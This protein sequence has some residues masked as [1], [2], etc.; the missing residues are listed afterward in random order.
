[1]S[2][3]RVPNDT[4]RAG[5]DEART[6]EYRSDEIGAVLATLRGGAQP[7]AP[8]VRPIEPPTRALRRAVEPGPSTVETRVDV[9]AATSPPSP[10]PGATIRRRLHR[11]LPMLLTGGLSAALGAAIAWVVVVGAAPAA[12]AS[13]PQQRTAHAPTHI[14]EVVSDDA[15][16]GDGGMTD[17]VA[18]PGQAS[19][20][21]ASGSLEAARDAYAQLARRHPR[22]PV[23]P[24]LARVLAH[25][26]TRSRAG[27]G[28]RCQL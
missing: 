21:L 5:D 24:L 12:P 3:P 16:L 2:D 6:R 11:H 15:D 28:R 8:G 14:E 13:G 19:G 27:E 25:C 23:Y 20:L 1:V 18:S 4:E 10:A 22:Q 26:G 9:E 7:G 17:A